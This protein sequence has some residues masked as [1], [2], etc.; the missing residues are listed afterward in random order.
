MRFHHLGLCASAGMILAYPWTTLLA[1]Y[2]LMGIPHIAMF[3]LGLAVM[4]LLPGLLLISS[5]WRFVARPES[6]LP[7]EY[8]P[9]HLFTLWLGFFFIH[10]GYSFA[11][12]R[13]GDIFSTM[14][15][16]NIPWHEA[17]FYPVTGLWWLM[18]NVL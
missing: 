1:V 18:T 3:F 16:E 14:G 2:A 5:I 13:S 15:G 7:A 11:L 8:G 12:S 6:R 9:A 4:L 10:A 17:V